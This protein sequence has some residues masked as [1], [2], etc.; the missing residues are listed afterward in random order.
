MNESLDTLVLTKEQ[1]EMQIRAI[2]Q[3]VAL[4]GANDSE[5]GNFEAIIQKL[6][7]GELEPVEALEQAHL[8]KSSKM[9]YH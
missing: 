2:L 6:D 3:E 7:A 5:F 4:I 9:D 8:I 1:A